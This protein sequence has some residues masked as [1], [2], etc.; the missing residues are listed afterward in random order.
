MTSTLPIGGLK[1]NSSDDP[2]TWNG[3]S[4]GLSLARVTSGFADVFPT[5]TFGKVLTATVPETGSDELVMAAFTLGVPLIPTFQTP[6]CCALTV[7]VTAASTFPV[8]GTGFADVFKTVTGALPA[9]AAGWL[10]R[11]DR[12]NAKSPKPKVKSISPP[13][14]FIVFLLVFSLRII[15]QKNRPNSDASSAP[16]FKSETLTEGRGTGPRHT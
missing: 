3:C 4:A 13:T 5:V 2:V 16:K 1:S 9:A 6:D 8:T 14:C 10:G 11:D 12:T 15:K 7:P